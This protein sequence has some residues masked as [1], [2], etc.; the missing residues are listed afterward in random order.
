[1]IRTEKTFVPPDIA[2]DHQSHGI[3]TRPGDR[4]IVISRSNWPEPY[5][6]ISKNMDS[7]VGS[8]GTLT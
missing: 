6:E 5:M 8:I 3:V 4:L 7:C 2:G 1:M